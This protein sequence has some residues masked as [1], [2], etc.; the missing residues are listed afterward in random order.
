MIR[1]PLRVAAVVGL[2]VAAWAAVAIPARA[3]VAARTTADEPQYLLTAVSLWEDRDLDIADELD[4][5]RQRAFFAAELPVQTS[6]LPDGRQVSPHD[7]LLP[8]LLQEF[9]DAAEPDRGLLMAMNAGLPLVDPTGGDR[10]AWR[11]PAGDHVVGLAGRAS[12]PAARSPSVATGTTLRSTASGV[13]TGVSTS[14]A[15]T[16]R[17]PGIARSRARCPASASLAARSSS[18]KYTGRPNTAQ[19]SSCPARAWARRRSSRMKPDNS[20]RN[21][22]ARPAT[23]V[24]PS[25]RLVPSKLFSD[26]IR[27]PS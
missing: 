11:A 10:L 22:S 23:S 9:A 2:V 6:R 19:D 24:W 4:A 27:R 26:R 20:S 16:A 21:G 7:P 1:S 14:A 18:T 17:T 3:T 12:A 25:I 15:S 8:V 13:S 5:R